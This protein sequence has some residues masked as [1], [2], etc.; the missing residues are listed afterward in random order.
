MANLFDEF[1][2]VNREEWI[3]KATKDMKGKNPIDSFSIPLSDTITQLPYYDNS[4]D[5]VDLDISGLFNDREFDS[6]YNT[7]KILIKNAQSAN[8]EGLKS[9]E[10]G[11]NGLLFISDSPTT[12]ISDVVRDISLQYCY[13]SL[14]DF[15]RD[16]IAQF[17]NT[18]QCT[19]HSEKINLSFVSSKKHQK[20]E[21]YFQSLLDLTK[22]ANGF[23]GVKTIPLYIGST[24]TKESIIELASILSEF[25]EIV[26]TDTNLT[27]FELF[28]RIIIQNTASNNYFFEICK[29]RALRILFHEL[30]LQYGLNNSKISIQT[31]TRRD[32]NELQMLL[33]NTTQSMAAIIGGTDSIVVN[34]NEKIP[35]PNSQR[36]SRNVSSLISEEGRLDKV[37]D[38]SAGS[39]Y[40][41]QLTLEIVNGAWTQFLQI[42]SQ[43]GFLKSLA[44]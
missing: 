38:P 15:D 2:K 20:D 27:I 21:R 12:I 44:R 36:I 10:S 22:A 42:E 28:N 32:E 33:S 3:E 16:Q 19:D 40:L 6:W 17:L 4:G 14:S 7:Q 31:E 30:G 23:P 5:R 9:L 24:T 13:V 11:C 25:V 41:D 43:G 39:Y 35:N 18:K 26:A 1:P 29:L 37:T 34:S 8:K